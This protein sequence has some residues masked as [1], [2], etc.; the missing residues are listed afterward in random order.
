[1]SACFRSQLNGSPLNLAPL[2]SIHFASSPSKQNESSPSVVS[3]WLFIGNERARSL[4]GSLKRHYG[5]S[6][7]P[8]FSHS[9]RSSPPTHGGRSTAN[10]SPL[11]VFSRS[12]TIRFSNRDAR[13]LEGFS[14]LL[15]N[16]WT[17]EDSKR[18]M[19]ECES[20]S[21]HRKYK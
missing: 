14:L 12:E 17:N 9:A 4:D 5:C 1:M 10:R 8:L 18:R 7:F 16:K 19:N 15:R 20:E 6:L 13:A 3:S 2:S 11:A 21:G